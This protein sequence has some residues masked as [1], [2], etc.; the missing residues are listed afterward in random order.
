[1][2]PGTVHGSMQPTLQ[3]Y[4]NG[5]SKAHI[6]PTQTYLESN[7]C[8]W[9]RHSSAVAKTALNLGIY[10]FFPVIPRY[11]EYC[12]VLYNVY[13]WVSDAKTNKK[14]SENTKISKPPDCEHAKVQ[15]K[16]GKNI[17]KTLKTETKSPKKTTSPKKP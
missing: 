6:T 13:I 3:L 15:Q 14:L 1:M 5:H 17:L 2:F 16:Y 12:R 8:K 9:R 7:A 11:Y 4:T 10:M